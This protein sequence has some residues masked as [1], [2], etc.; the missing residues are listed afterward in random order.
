MIE[1]MIERKRDE[2]TSD[3]ID[4]LRWLTRGQK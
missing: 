4:R 3:L 1:S 2:Y